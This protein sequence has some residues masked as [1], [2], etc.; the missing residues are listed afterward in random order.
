MLFHSASAS[1]MNLPS[2]MDS[3]TFIR[4]RPHRNGNV[5]LHAIALRVM[6]HYGFDPAFSAGSKAQVQ[7]LQQHDPRTAQGSQVKDMTGL[8]WSSID[9]DTSRDL[10]QIE[11]AEKLSDGTFRV[12]V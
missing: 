12:R 9:N 8:L 2:R 1:L 5:N 11:V 4:V 7:Q 10:D 6:K 3:C